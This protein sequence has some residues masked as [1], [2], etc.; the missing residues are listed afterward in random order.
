MP[1]AGD[2]SPQTPTS[3]PGSPDVAGQTSCGRTFGFTS[4]VVVPSPLEKYS[5]MLWQ[6]ASHA[7]SGPV[8]HCAIVALGFPLHVDGGSVRSMVICTLMV[9]WLVL[10]IF[11]QPLA[12]GA[13]DVPTNACAAKSRALPL[14]STEMSP[15]NFAPLGQL[16]ELRSFVASG[17][18]PLRPVTVPL[19]ALQSRLPDPS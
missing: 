7:A 10:G 5:S 14:L 1:P 8:E 2:L 12:I 4:L 13:E 19:V 16:L 9:S 11:V 6:F 3:R 18:S 17:V 15:Q